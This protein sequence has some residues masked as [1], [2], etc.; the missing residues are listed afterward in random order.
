MGKILSEFLT[1]RAE[2]IAKMQ[3]GGWDETSLSALATVQN[4]IAAVQ[5]EIARSNSGE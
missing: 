5:A 4:A 3:T 1:K 2:I